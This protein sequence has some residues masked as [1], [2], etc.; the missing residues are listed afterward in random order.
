[1]G[2]TSKCKIVSSACAPA[3]GEVCAQTSRLVH[4]LM[5]WR[6]TFPRCL[7]I[8]FFPDVFASSACL[9]MHTQRPELC[10]VASRAVW[11]CWLEYLLMSSHRWFS[12]MSLHLP[13]RRL[14]SPHRR[15][16]RR[17]AVRV[18]HTLPVQSLLLCNIAT[19][20]MFIAL[21]VASLW[22]PLRNASGLVLLHPATARSC[23]SRW[24]IAFHSTDFDLRNRQFVALRCRR[25]SF[26]HQP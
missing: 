3:N 7:S 16:V 12:P 6:R 5:S 25:R 20:P 23:F 21:W 4:Y 8:E 18:L 1:M 11:P 24:F 26:R 2:A 15:R 13:F 10:P 19:L 9:S 22:N 14:I 17:G